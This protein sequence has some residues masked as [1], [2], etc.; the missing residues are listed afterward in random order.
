MTQRKLEALI[1]LA[2]AVLAAAFYWLV[3]PVYAPD[4]MFAETPP[5][6]LPKACTLLIGALGGMMF[7]HRGF[8]IAEDGSPPEL[9]LQ[10]LAQMAVITAC[11]AASILFMRFAGYLAGGAVLV[12][13]LMVYMRTR[14]LVRIALTAAAAPVALYALFELLLGVPLP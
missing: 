14:N 2:L 9:S 11:F 1:G 6:L 7:L 5:S 8:L 12:A 4:S 13:A 3:I 10:D